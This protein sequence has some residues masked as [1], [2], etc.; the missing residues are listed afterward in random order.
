MRQ[1]VVG[2]MGVDEEDMSRSSVSVAQNLR[3]ILFQRLG[4]KIQ[5]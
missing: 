2:M 3:R 1:A 5:I 4:D